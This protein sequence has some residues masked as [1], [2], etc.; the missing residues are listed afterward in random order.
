M[1][2]ATSYGEI[3]NPLIVISFNQPAGE[4]GQQYQ[5]A[6]IE[7]RCEAITTEG[8]VRNVVSKTNV[9]QV[10]DTKISLKQIYTAMNKAT[11]GALLA[12]TFKEAMLEALSEDVT[13]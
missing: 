5:P 9:G 11:V 10:S 13:L 2:L 4:N 12:N 6:V 8:A 1:P 3:R 7:T